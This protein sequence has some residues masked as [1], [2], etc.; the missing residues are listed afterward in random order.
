MFQKLIDSN[1][2]TTGNNWNPPNYLDY[3]RFNEYDDGFLTN[4]Y[5]G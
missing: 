4:L 3:R 1:L 2:A 5:H